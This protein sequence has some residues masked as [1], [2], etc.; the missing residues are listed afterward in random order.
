MIEPFKQQLH[1]SWKFFVTTSHD[2]VC[3]NDINVTFLNQCLLFPGHSCSVPIASTP[4]AIEHRRESLLLFHVAPSP[5]SLSDMFIPMKTHLFPFSSLHICSEFL[6]LSSFVFSDCD[7]VLLQFWVFVVFVAFV[8]LFVIIGW[9]VDCR[10]ESWKALFS[11]KQ[12]FC[13]ES[14][15][16]K[17]EVVGQ[18]KFVNLCC[19]CCHHC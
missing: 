6:L 16:W 7:D 17:F 5:L 18:L 8:V 19:C 12:S 4:E 1:G 10:S 11:L 15:G 9:V 2:E 13:N 14:D 3:C